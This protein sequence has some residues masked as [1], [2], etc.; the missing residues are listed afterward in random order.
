MTFR[1]RSAVLLAAALIAGLAYLFWPRGPAPV[2]AREEGS[3]PTLM[4]MTSL[5]IMFGERFSLD[6]NGSPALTALEQRYRVV[7]IGIADA[8]SL[9][10]GRLLLMAHA[11][12][13]PAQALV[14]LDAWVR[15]GGRLLLLADPALEWPSERPLGDRLR[16]APM[17]MDTGLLAHWGLALK[18]PAERGPAMRQLAG[19]EIETASPGRLSG[20][21]AISGDA[22]V[23]R[24]AIGKGKVTVVADA[25]FLNIADLDGPTDRNLDA[26]VAELA[27]LETS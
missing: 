3:R 14:D 26:L 8:G 6:G 23:A 4:L 20:D 18:A 19:R 2:E 5:P 10:Q 22:L 24:C 27:R 15:S 12:A 16:P 13:Q 1:R 25:D 17:F 11:S 7:P 9:K 21:C